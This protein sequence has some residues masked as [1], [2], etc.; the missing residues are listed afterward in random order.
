MDFGVNKTAVEMIN[1]GTF[2][3]TY[4]SDIYAGVTGKWYKK[5]METIWSVKR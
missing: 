3:G 1:K 5:F 2:G 4:F